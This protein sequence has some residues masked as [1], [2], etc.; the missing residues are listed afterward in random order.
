M[1]LDLVILLESTIFEGNK[2]KAAKATSVDTLFM[3]DVALKQG[4]Y[5]D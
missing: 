2:S 5:K 3:Y 4:P 1:N